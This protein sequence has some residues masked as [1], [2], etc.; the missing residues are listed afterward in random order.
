MF[1]SLESCFNSVKEFQFYTKY[2]TVKKK[3]KKPRRGWKQ[4]MSLSFFQLKFHSVFQGIQGEKIVKTWVFPGVPLV[5]TL[6]SLC[7][8]HRLQEPACCIA[9]PKNRELA[10]DFPKHYF[11]WPENHLLSNI[12]FKKRKTI[13]STLICISLVSLSFIRKVP[14]KHGSQP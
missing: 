1:I 4:D 9:Q 13:Y 3:K 2:K 12:I 10:L 7:R 8:V 5:K 6:H 11:L 14:A